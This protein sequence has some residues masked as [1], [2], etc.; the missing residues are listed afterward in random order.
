MKSIQLR[1][2]CCSPDTLGLRPNQFSMMAILDPVTKLI[3][4]FHLP[5]RFSQPYLKTDFKDGSHFGYRIETISN[6]HLGFGT[7][8]KSIFWWLG[9]SWKQI[10]EMATILDRDYFQYIFIYKLPQCFILSI[11]KIDHCCSREANHRFSR[12]KPWQLLWFRISTIF[13]YFRPNNCQED[14]H[15]ASSKSTQWFQKRCW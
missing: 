9:R 3:K 7:K 5:V 11:I 15:Q 14:P 10:L 1:K 12:W 2:C 6:G 4:K 13:G 8:I